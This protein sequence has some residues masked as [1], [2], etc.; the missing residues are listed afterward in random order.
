MRIAV[1]LLR[2]YDRTK[3]DLP[4]R[5]APTP[6]KTLV[7]E[8][9]LQQ[10]GVAMVV[11]YFERFIARFPTLGALGRGERG[12]GDGALV[13]ARLLR[14]GAKSAPGG[15]GGGRRARRRAA[16][17]R[18]GARRAAGP[19]PLHGGGGGGDR[20]R[21]ADLRPR[22]Q[23]RARDGAPRR[24]LR[25]DRRARRRAPRCAPPGTR[26]VP[27]ARPGDFTQAV[28]ELGATICTPRSPRCDACP[29][30]AACAARA[31][32]TVDDIPRR[33]TQGGAP[34]GARRL[35][36][37][38]RRRARAAAQAPRR[39][40]GRDLVAA[41][42]G[43][44]RGRGARRRR[45]G[46]AEGGRRGRRSFREARAPRRRPAGL[47]PPRRHGRGLPRSTSRAP[48]AR[49]P[50]VAGW[51]STGWPTLGVSSFTRKT[52]RRSGCA[53]K[54]DNAALRS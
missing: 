36:L 41:R 40:P 24:R 53:A 11:P 13:G 30:R 4:W 25:V 18:G 10:T 29:V 33:S 31:A 21:R 46:G 42:G 27:R 8:L 17:D 5:R 34:G 44:R 52:V 37:R 23:R 20:L 48:G 9:M 54:R 39:P 38:D 35:R 12:G 15:A 3:R 19:R 1:A 26:Q 6:Y 14:A 22:R 16:A 43:R 49:G 32:G 28:M 51:R 45:R 50:T 2:W 47:H 7:S